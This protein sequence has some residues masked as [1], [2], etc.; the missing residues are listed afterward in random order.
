MSLANAHRWLGGAALA[1]RGVRA[2]L[3]IGADAVSEQLGR[4]LPRTPEQL[5]RADVVNRLL[6]TAAPAS[7]RALPP[8]ESV[9]L[10]GVDFESSNCIN[11]L[12]DLDF[13]TRVGTEAGSD[14]LPK[15]AYVKLPCA[16]RTTRIFANAMGFWPLECLF[17]EQVAHQVPIRVPR[18]YAVAQ[19]G[20]RFALLLENL[21]ET[22]GARLFIN[23]DMAAGTTPERAERVLDAFAEMHAH[24]WAWPDA[25][26]EALLPERFNTYT[27]PRWRG[28][29]RALNAMAIEPARKAAPELVTDEVAATCHLAIERWDEMIEWWYA[30]PR[31]LCHG[32]SHL[33]NCFE[34]PTDE[35]LR[36]GMIDFQAVHWAP[37]MRD[38]QYFLI[39]SLEPDVLA[40]HEEALIRG[41]CEALAK[42]GVELGFDD[43]FAQYRAFSYQTLMVG[44][45]PLGLSALTE[46]DETV[47]AITRRSTAAVARL[48]LRDWIEELR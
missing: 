41:Y 37:G 29:T 42:R 10:S 19:R 48:G 8:V 17:C 21:H 13:G 23:R 47:L 5:A 38:V 28:I 30:S 35:G 11:F 44:V 46:R 4:A 39:N 3:Q 34:Y 25:A 7:G 43:A 14:A 32:D 1:G 22:P 33:G 9:S 18:V 6:S 16:E 31:T 27:A 40:S 45:V 26:R 2:A 36:V 15:T 12:V 20:S 24:F